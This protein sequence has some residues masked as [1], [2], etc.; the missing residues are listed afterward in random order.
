MLNLGILGLICLVIITPLLLFLGIP[1]LAVLGGATLTVMGFAAFGKHPLN[2]L[3]ILAGTLLA[4]FAIWFIDSRFLLM[5]SPDSAL[6]IHV[7]ISAIF[8]ATC[9]S[10][11]SKKYGWWAGVITGIIHM[12]IVMTVRSFQGGFNLYNNGFAAGF[13]GAI[14]VPFFESFRKEEISDLKISAPITVETPIL[15]DETTIESSGE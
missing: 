13:V 5:N 3:P 8:F 9:L 2:A 4:F 6:N 1:F 7:Y 15:I 11:V 12:T 14:V 10:P